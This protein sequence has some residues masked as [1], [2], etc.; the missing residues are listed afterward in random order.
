[1]EGIQ[2]LAEICNLPN[3][4]CAL[5]FTHSAKKDRTAYDYLKEASKNFI[6]DYIF[7]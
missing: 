5:L 4:K 3:K 2:T 1:V 7:F 6:N